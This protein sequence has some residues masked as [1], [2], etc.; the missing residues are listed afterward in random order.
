MRENRRNPSG[1]GH[2]A[3]DTASLL[4]EVVSTTPA[5]SLLVPTRNG[6]YRDSGYIY[7][8]GLEPLLQFV[9]S[10]GF[11]AF[12]F[13][14]VALTIFFI[15]HIVYLILKLGAVKEKKEFYRE[16]WTR[17][18]APIKKDEFVARWAKIKERMAKMEEAE[19]KLA[20]IEADKLFDEL[21][22]RMMYKGKD[23]GERLQQITSEQLS[24]INA[25]WESHK[26]RN[27]LSHDINY[28]INYSDAE[29]IIQ[30]YKDAF[31]E[32]EILD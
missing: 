25:V 21:L 4:L 32:L 23:M 27:M 31:R 15:I 14:F 29:R 26:A 8:M 17:K 18:A 22:R 6:Q 19:Y 13:I 24:N 1:Y 9:N 20:I 7:E 10:S 16:L 3:P 12:K 28:H 30:N 5:S 2:S 11:L